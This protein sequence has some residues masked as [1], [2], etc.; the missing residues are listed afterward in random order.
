MR[1]YDT[2]ESPHGGMLLVASDDGLAGVYFDR[3]KHHPRLQADWE[4]NPRHRVLQ[5]AKRELE[6]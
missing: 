4:R 1:Y 2:F 5:Q 3:Q 6:E